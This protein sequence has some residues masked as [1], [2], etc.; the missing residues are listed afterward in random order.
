MDKLKN[1]EISVMYGDSHRTKLAE[2]KQENE[3]T[4]NT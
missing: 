2:E 1:P 3:T 4:D